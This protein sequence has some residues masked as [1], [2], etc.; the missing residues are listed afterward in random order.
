MPKEGIPYITF[1]GN[2]INSQPMLGPSAPCP[3]CG[4]ECKIKNGKPPIMQFIDCCGA[5]Y[6][7]GI[8][9]RDISGIPANDS[10]MVD[11]DEVERRMPT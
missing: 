1:D 2:T 10:G 4:K 9:G 7:V 11:I 8:K 3:I 6:L 5:S